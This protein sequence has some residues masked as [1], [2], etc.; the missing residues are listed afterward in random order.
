MKRFVIA[1]S[2][3]QRILK[4]QEKKQLLART[5]VGT[6]LERKNF[7]LEDLKTLFDIV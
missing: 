5:T 7:Q 4:F 2:V 3:E 6:K 1:N